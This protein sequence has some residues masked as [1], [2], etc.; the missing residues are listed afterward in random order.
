MEF[1]CLCLGIQSDS[2]DSGKSVAERIRMAEEKK[3]HVDGGFATRVNLTASQSFNYP[4]RGELLN[5]MGMDFFLF[6]DTNCTNA[7]ND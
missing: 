3:K 2:A 7:R 5:S 4:S 6:L 1:A